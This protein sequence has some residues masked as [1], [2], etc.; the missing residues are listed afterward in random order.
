MS[1]FIVLESD[2]KT[3]VTGNLEVHYIPEKASSEIQVTP[4]TFEYINLNG[5]QLSTDDLLN[6]GRGHYKI[7]V[8]IIKI[9]LI[10]FIFNPYIR[11]LY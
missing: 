8:I 11:T 7:K 4:K 6:L 1:P 10:I 9:D 3:M 2:K 5:N